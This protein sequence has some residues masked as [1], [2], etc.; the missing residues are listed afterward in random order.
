MTI[1]ATPPLPLDTVTEWGR[2]GMVGV[3]GGERYYWMV[4]DDGT[5]SMVPWFM[6]ERPS[7]QQLDDRNPTP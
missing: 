7:D 1:P 6:V 3:T 4:D 2:I 5:V